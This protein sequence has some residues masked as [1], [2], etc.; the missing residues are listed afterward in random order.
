[1]GSSD[2]Q[3]E[4]PS[5]AAPRR[6][7]GPVAWAAIAVGGVVLVAGAAFAG[8]RVAGVGR[9][10]TPTPACVESTL[11]LGSTRYRIEPVKRPANGSLPA[12]KN[13]ADV[14]SW[15][16]GTDINYVFVLANA[17]ANLALRETLKQGGQATIVWANC[18]ST[19]YALAAPESRP[20]D[21]PTLLDQSLSGITVFVPDSPAGGGWEA[22]GE[23]AGET[24]TDVDTPAPATGSVQAEISLLSSQS[25]DDG[26]NVTIEVSVSNVGPDSFAVRKSDVTLTPQ[27]GEPV[28]PTSAEPVLPREV[29]AG[30]TETF[31]F[32]FPSP[33]SGTAVFRLFDAEY[34]VE[35][36]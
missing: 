12:P 25:S 24:L 31:W 21:D 3:P 32:T 36:S 18:N 29:A 9:P 27:G 10:P 14:A 13:V 30:A 16:K 28:K 33:G 11:V 2:T 22:R 1:M 20:A 26:K 19:A 6:R 5:P 7:L 17:P 23:L 4:T 35:G 8:L 34:D 15:V